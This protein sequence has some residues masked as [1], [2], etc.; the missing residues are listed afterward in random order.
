[1]AHE[2]I[3]AQ[4]EAQLAADS[5]AKSAAQPEA[6]TGRR[7]RKMTEAIEAEMKRQESLF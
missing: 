4:S 1:L 5:A 2:L 7:I 6:E 3:T